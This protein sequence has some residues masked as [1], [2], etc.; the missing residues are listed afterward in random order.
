LRKT[1]KIKFEDLEELAYVQAVGPDEE[2]LEVIV[3]PSQIDEEFY[4][5]LYLEDEG[6]DWELVE[7]VD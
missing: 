7:I 6:K 1:I 3:N 5:E 4:A 2:Y